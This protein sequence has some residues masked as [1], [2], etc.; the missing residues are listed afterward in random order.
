MRDI[1]ATTISLVDVTGGDA[2]E[3]ACERGLAWAWRIRDPR[4]D[5]S[6]QPSGRLPEG[7]GDDSTSVEWWSVTREAAARA[8]T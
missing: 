6:M 4:P 2:F 8:L 7:A 3:E 1:Y 5:L